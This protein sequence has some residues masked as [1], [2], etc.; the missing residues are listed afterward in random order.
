M[1]NK[2]KVIALCVQKDKVQLESSSDIL[3][4]WNSLQRY[5]CCIW[6][7]VENYIWFFGRSKFNSKKCVR[8]YYY[9][10]TMN[11]KIIIWERYKKVQNLLLFVWQLFMKR[12][13]IVKSKDCSL[14]MF[15]TKKDWIFFQVYILCEFGS[16]NIYFLPEGFSINFVRTVCGR[17]SFM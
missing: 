11:W 13:E 14:K 16:S 15:S 3:N 1:L 8:W 6:M 4:S 7:H 17:H 12:T 10:L 2:Q 5:D 9:L